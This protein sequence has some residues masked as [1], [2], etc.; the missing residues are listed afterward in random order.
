M[1]VRG[2]TI[3][4]FILVIIIVG[5]FVLQKNNSA[6]FKGQIEKNLNENKITEH[7]D[8][9]AKIETLA[10]VEGNEDIRVS[11]T[12]SNNGVAAIPKGKPFKY[13]IY[14]NETEVFSNTDSYSSVEPGD[15]FNFIYPISRTI[16][17]YEDSGTVKFVVDSEDEISESNE[18]NNSVEIE[19]S[20]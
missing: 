12:V 3:F 6:L 11:A 16:Y 18:E 2:K 10:P 17:Q 20:F 14:I 9:V 13:I 7:I 15:S 4:T 8:L 1:G 19:Y 5:V